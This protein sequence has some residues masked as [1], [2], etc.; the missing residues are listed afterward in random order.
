VLNDY[1]VLCNS[2]LCLSVTAGLLSNQ[3]YFKRGLV[4]PA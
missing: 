1:S 3:H 2:Q 4:L